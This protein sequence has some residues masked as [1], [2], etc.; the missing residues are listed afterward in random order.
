M[1]SYTLFTVFVVDLL[2]TT[3]D[4]TLSWTSPIYP[5]LYS[6][7]T[8]INPLPEPI[9][10]QQDAWLGSLVTIGA[11]VGP[12]P[13]SFIAEKYGRKIGLLSI[14]LP[15]AIA[16]L[17]MAF[18][19]NIYWFYLGRVLGGLALGGGYTLVPMY[20]AEVSQDSNRGAMSQTINV[21]TSIGNF[22]PYAIGPYLS[23]KWFNMVLS[24]IP[25]FSFL[26][27]LFIGPETPHYLVSIN[28][29]EKAEKALMLL[30]SQDKK[31]VEMELYSIRS[32]IKQT[33][34]GHFSDILR[35]KGLRK[36]LIICLILIIAQEL[37]GFC[38]ITF[39]LQPIFETVGARI[40]P[41]VSAL[42]VG[43]S[44]LGSSF[45]PLFLIDRAGRRFLTIYSCLG[46]FV[47]LSIIGTFFYLQDSTDINVKPYFFVLILSLIFF[48]ISFNFGICSVPWTLTSEMFP[49]NVK[50]I[51]ASAVSCTCWIISFV[52]TKFFNDMNS[53]MGRAG[54]FWFFAGSCLV[55]TFFS[56]V[57]LPETKGKS[58]KEI[59][60]MLNGV[61]Y[62]E[63]N[64]SEK[65]KMLNK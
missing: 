17:I 45:F 9:T 34:N 13:F 42:I 26:V 35:S 64:I 18:A 14:A 1:L 36:A 6:N 15:H 28:E 51:S 47:S 19:K 55:T 3:G 60:E 41:D 40:P 37:C 31:E 20:I 63:E 56:I 58:F 62:D 30:R 16:Y 8:N 54:T 22:L 48:I 46:M 53:A 52:V 43:L 57:Y 5:K 59:Q 50:H 11:M 10:E 44:M 21:F 49:N 7:D 24:A 25:T 27:F 29:I 12:F 4:V 61:T 65:E 32:H 2:S 39:Y 38:A 23:I 33:E